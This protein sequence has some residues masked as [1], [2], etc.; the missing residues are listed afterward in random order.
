[1]KHNVY[2]G[3]GHRVLDGASLWPNT[4]ILPSLGQ[5]MHGMERPV[6]F[7]CNMKLLLL[8]DVYFALCNIVMKHIWVNFDQPAN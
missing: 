2:D 1:M 4:C 6:T 5:R 8:Y 3:E 7:D